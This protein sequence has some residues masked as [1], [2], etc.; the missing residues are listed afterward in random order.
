MEC[1]GI[2]VEPEDESTD[3]LQEELDTSISVGQNEMKQPIP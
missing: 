3:G 1:T 2:T